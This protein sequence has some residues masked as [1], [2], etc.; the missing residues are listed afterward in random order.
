MEENKETQTPPAEEETPKKSNRELYMERH[1]QDFPD[2]DP[3]DE[4]A[5]YGRMNE[6]YAE[7]DRLRQNDSNFRK[8]VNEHPE[9][10]GM[11]S[12][13]MDGRNFIESFLSRNSKEDINAAYDDPEMAQKLAE[14]QAKYMKEQAD[15]KQ[16]QEEGEAN[17]QESIKRLEAYCEANGIDEEGATKIWGAC[18][19][20]GSN[21]LKGNF[22]DELFDI[23]HKGMNHDD[24]VAA[25]REEGELAGHNAKVQTQLAKGAGP[26]G[27]PPTFDGGQ[28]AAAPE[29]Q[30]QKRKGKLPLSG[31]EFE[32]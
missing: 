15:R 31:K 13:M 4:E 32:Y 25:A 26:Q 12:D 6:R 2:D 23:V 1:R 16:L 3:N 18:L 22:P 17:V 8:L 14:G 27:L 24:D 9:Y 10:G 19:D 5:M 28:G 7:L 20:F 21:V 30:P 11:V 29:G